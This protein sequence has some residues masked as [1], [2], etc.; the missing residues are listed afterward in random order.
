MCQQRISN[1]LKIAM[2]SQ[3]YSGLEVYFYLQKPV[4]LAGWITVKVDFYH[5]Q[6]IFFTSRDMKI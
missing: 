4:K 6:Y 2:D 5:I 1:V 3:Q